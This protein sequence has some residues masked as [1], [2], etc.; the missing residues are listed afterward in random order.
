MFWVN[1]IVVAGGYDFTMSSIFCNFVAEQHELSFGFQYGVRFEEN[2]VGVLDSDLVCVVTRV[3]WV[4][5]CWRWY[6]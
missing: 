5:F 6:K 4:I 3:F 2:W 1:F